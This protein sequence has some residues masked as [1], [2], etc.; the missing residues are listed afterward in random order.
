MSFPRTRLST[1]MSGSASETEQ[2]LRH[3]FAKHKRPALA[4]VAVVGFS[5]GLC[6]S[7]VACRTQMG[8]EQ[9]LDALYDTAA[10]SFGQEPEREELAC[11]QGRGGTLVAAYFYDDYPR[12][13]LAIGV[14]DEDAQVT[15]PVFSTHFAGGRPHVSTFEKDGVDYLLYTANGGGQGS[16]YGEA[17]LIAFDGTDFTWVWP[18]EGDVRQQD[19]RAY[20]AYQTYWAGK[21][22]LLCSG[23]VEIFQQSEDF[24]PMSPGDKQWYFSEHIRFVQ[25]ETAVPD[26]IT[27]ELR[28]VLEDATRDENNPWQARNTSALWQIVQV[29]PG[30]D[31]L[32]GRRYTLLARADGEDGTWLGMDVLIHINYWSPGEPFYIPY[33]LRMTMGTREEAERIFRE[34]NRQV[35]V[36]NYPVTTASGRELSVELEMEPLYQEPDYFTVEQIRVYENGTLL[37]TIG[38]G[39]VFYD[40]DH[41]FDGLFVLQGY[42]VGEPDLRD[43]NFDGAPDLGLLGAYHFPK[44]VS[45]G[46]FLW[47]EKAGKFVWS[48]V[49]FS[50]LT[51]DGEKKQVIER[52]AGYP[53][54]QNVYAWDAAGTLRWIS[55]PWE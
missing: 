29:T 28:Q 20:Q 19:S 15:A 39:D 41:E 8:Q 30:E 3:L 45:Y 27:E 33:A 1:R 40:G 55:G 24:L 43:L 7:L 54:E 17:G 11:I 48:T 14:E 23:G 2:R 34:E 32:C 44:N 5:I 16:T 51:L 21:K 31:T 22:A 42:S 13:T 53:P 38:A 35:R 37:Q 4:L 52:L 47:D 10:M 9:R 46:W 25:E 26:E 12:Y 36:E 18:V 6:G 49:L 50:D